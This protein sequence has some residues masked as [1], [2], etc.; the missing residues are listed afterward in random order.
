M[1]I[2]KNANLPSLHYTD[3][4]NQLEMSPKITITANSV[5]TMVNEI[6]KIVAI[7]LPLTVPIHL[8]QMTW[9]NCCLIIPKICFNGQ[10]SVAH[11]TVFYWMFVIFTTQ[12][13]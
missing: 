3:Q 5:C 6:L 2:N 4:F 11:K 7:L 13:P 1:E 12:K 10:F 9:P 8:R